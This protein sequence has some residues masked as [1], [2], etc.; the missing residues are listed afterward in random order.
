LLKKIMES[1]MS[2]LS[3]SARGQDCQI[4]I[5]GYCNHNPETTVLC[6][7]NGAGLAMK[8]DDDEGAYGCSDCH[9]I[10]DRSGVGTEYMPETVELMF[11]QAVQRTRAIMK[12]AG[13][14]FYV[15]MTGKKN[16]ILPRKY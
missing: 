15:G 13:L 6:H 7:M 8:A 1:A 4:R 9:A 12:Q 2:I 10:V 16:K 3:S 5:P 11:R 14:I